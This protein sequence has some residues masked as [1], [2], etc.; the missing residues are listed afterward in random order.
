[1]KNLLFLFCCLVAFSCRPAQENQSIPAV[2]TDSLAHNLSLF[3]GKKISIE[4]KII[5]VCPVE[6]RKMKLSGDGRQIVKIVLP[7]TMERFE[8]SWNGKRVK[9]TG[10]VREE[11]ISRARIDSIEA[12]G[13]LLCHIDHTPCIDSVWAGNMHRYGKAEEATR[14]SVAY[15]RRIVEK[16]GK[17][18]VSVIVMVAD[19][20]EEIKI[21]TEQAGRGRDGK[22]SPSCNGCPLCGLCLAKA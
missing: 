9:V 7:D 10:T 4:G 16:T 19:K 14:Q 13:T 5:H 18:Y 11:R 15:L 17:D 3:E 6:G 1:M 12:A 22:K 20:V 2:T 8:D 21:I